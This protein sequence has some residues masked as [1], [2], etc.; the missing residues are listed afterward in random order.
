MWMLDDEE[1]EFS[2]A[3]Q[4]LA[5]DLMPIVAAAIPD[6][7][8]LLT[9]TYRLIIDSLFDY[10]RQPRDPMHSIEGAIT[11]DLPSDS[12]SLSERERIA[13]VKERLLDLQDPDHKRQVPALIALVQNN[14]IG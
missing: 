14:L 13:R 9:P 10:D 12:A 11:L 5:H 6:N 1:S 4:A 8:A 3:L 2:N 7:P